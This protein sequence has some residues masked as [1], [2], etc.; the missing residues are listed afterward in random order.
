EQ[1]N[2]NPRVGGSSPSA[3]TRILPQ[4]YNLRQFSFGKTNG[5]QRKVPGT[6][7]EEKAPLAM[8]EVYSNIYCDDSNKY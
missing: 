4:A 1:R 5:F 3:A 7:P 2:H 8:N 6:R